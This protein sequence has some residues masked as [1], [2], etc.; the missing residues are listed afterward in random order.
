[1][2][3][4]DISLNKGVRRTPSFA[5]NGE[6]AECVNLYPKNGELRNIPVMTTLKD[7]TGESDFVL[8]SGHTLLALHTTDSKKIY[9]SRKAA[10]GST[11]T[12]ELYS[13]LWEDGV[14]QTSGGN[15]VKITDFT[16]DGDARIL[17]LG[18]MMMVLDGAGLHYFIWKNGSYTR[19]GDEIP[20]LEM[21]FGLRGE[22]ITSSLS[23]VDID[24]S[25]V[26]SPAPDGYLPEDS[27]GH[28]RTISNLAYGI[29]ARLTA[30]GAR[31]GYFTH[32]FFVRYGL[33]LYDETVTAISAPVLMMVSNNELFMESRNWHSSSTEVDYSMVRA[34]LDYLIP[35]D[36]MSQYDDWKDLVKGI[37]IYVSAPI[38]TYK[39]SGSKIRLFGFPNNYPAF[40][41][42]NINDLK[43]SYGYTI[44]RL[45]NISSTWNASARPFYNNNYVKRDMMLVH[46]ISV[47][48]DQVQSQMAGTGGWNALLQLEPRDSG[49][50]EADMAGEG[51][52][53]LLKSY[54][55]SEIKEGLVDSDRPTVDLPTDRLTNIATQ[56]VL[57]ET[58]TFENIT[59]VSD[60]L[61]YNRR[62]AL[63]DITENVKCKQSLY[64][65]LA[66]ANAWQ[67]W[68]CASSGD[69]VNRPIKDSSDWEGASAYHLTV[70]MQDMAGDAIRV[71]DKGIMQNG[72]SLNIRSA[73]LYL[74]YL[75]IDT[76]KLFVYR[77]DGEGSSLT[78]VGISLPSLKKNILLNGTYYYSGALITNSQLEVLSDSAIAPTASHSKSFPSRMLLS[79]VENP[80]VY[81]LRNQY[82]IGAGKILRLS[83]LTEPLST[84]QY[85]QFP[86]VAFCSDGM[87]ALEVKKEDG[88]LHDPAPM[89]PDVLSNLDSVTA[90]EGGILYITRQGLKFLGENK[91]IRLLSGTLEGK[92]IDE[93]IYVGTLSQIYP[94]VSAW[95]RLFAADTA[96]I[97]QALQQAK[98]AYDYKNAMIHLFL[99]GSDKH[100]VLSLNGYEFCSQV[101]PSGQTGKPTALI[102]DY[103][104]SVLQFGTTALYVYDSTPRQTKDYGFCLSRILTF[105]EAEQYVNVLQMKV[106]HDADTV[107]GGA[108][109]KTALYVSNDKHHWALLPSLKGASYKYFRFALFTYMTDL[110]A[111]S[112]ISMLYKTERT[113]KLR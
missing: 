56:T 69:Y 102:E 50:I 94:Y 72:T 60:A 47:R 11:T 41:P 19:L 99:D 68:E 2:D 88:T 83:A 91:E 3:R 52:Y 30:E 55:L 73:L 28:V 104:A 63:S 15:A 89:S 70:E 25:N 48:T 7:G 44:S 108:Q 74:S 35:A 5:E 31:D 96:E 12:F 78:A 29:A 106:Y 86:V 18:R 75:D 65:L 20:K 13:N 9:I 84:G 59:S 8:E 6:M 90:V 82:E 45:T 54:D 34:K 112:G 17:T 95:A 57:K 67:G 26:D 87:Y 39:A 46:A 23:N 109:V 14:A 49:L 110:D 92:N 22:I 24:T 100:T 33:R 61:L 77:Y 93:S 21:Q 97:R 103:T 79:E 53:F 105:S 43:D 4:L 71:D 51:P 85:G 101:N 64:S 111:V 1:M 66:K 80:F 36:T 107:S 81:L 40:S 113:N 58:E 27:A 16:T 42:S 76:T 32:P 38:Y 37:N 62:L 98:L 10:S